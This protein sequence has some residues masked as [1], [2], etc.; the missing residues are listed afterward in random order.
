MTTSI[1]REPVGRRHRRSLVAA[2]FVLVALAG[3]GDTQKFE[4]TLHSRDGSG[5][6]TAGPCEYVAVPEAHTASLDP[7]FS[8]TI[9]GGYA[10]CVVQNAATTWIGPGVR[11][12]TTPARTQPSSITTVE[13]G[14]IDCAG[15]H[16]DLDFFSRWGTD[17]A[18]GQDSWEVDLDDG[19]RLTLVARTGLV[20]SAGFNTPL[21]MEESGIWR[22]TAGDLLHRTGTYRLVYDTIQAVLQLQE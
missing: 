9:E 18:L 20:V 11:R 5:G 21:C 6:A 19:R 12:A 1:A 2:V 13:Y 17:L 10:S 22:G 16:H 4:L 14:A 7:P 15:Q 3:C 8:P